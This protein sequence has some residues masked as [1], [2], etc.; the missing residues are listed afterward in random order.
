M[1]AVLVLV[2]LVVIIKVSGHYQEESERQER[3]ENK[4]LQ[5]VWGDI[6]WELEKRLKGVNYL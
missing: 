4:G 3:Q 2:P 1:A 5:S 6:G